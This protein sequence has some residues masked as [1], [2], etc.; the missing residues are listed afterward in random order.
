M[1]ILSLLPSATEI[2][3]ALGLEEDLVGVTHECDWPPAA[4]AKRRVSFSAL[5]PAA[6]PGD[7]DQLVSASIDG[8]EPI[9]RLDND[10]VRE[11][12][13]DLVLTQDLCAVCAVPSGHVNAALEVL[14]CRAEVLSMDPGALDEVLNCVLEVGAAT[15]TQ[16][17]ATT[18]VESLR[19]RL[20]AVSAAVAG[21]D[22]PR[23]FA[24]EWSDPP[25]NAGHWVPGMI[26]L[27]GGEPVLASAGSPSVR[28]GW[29]QIAAAAPQVVVFMPCGYDLEAASSEA[30]S[31]LG[32]AE[33][34][35][36]PAL[37]AVDASAHFSRP[38]PRLVDGVEI[39]AS[40][41]HGDAVAPCPPGTLRRIR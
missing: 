29:E 38:G 27:A 37:F 22:R 7:I 34:A 19:A 17:R 26:E 40:A 9:Y 12:R 32:R 35:G 6:E 24:L 36:V 20:R 14:G 15:G 21:R 3:Y 41:L 30:A 23:T 11:L 18:L 10:A 25:F 1:R 31:F 39:L 16:D 2:V 33:L 28:V 5:P 13:P 8:G 4:G